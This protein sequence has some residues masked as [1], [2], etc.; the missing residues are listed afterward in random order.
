MWRPAK[1][2]PRLGALLAVAISGCILPTDGNIVSGIMGCWRD[3]PATTSSYNTVIATINRYVNGEGQA[4]GIVLRVVSEV[5]WPIHDVSQEAMYC[6]D[7]EVH[8]NLPPA[9]RRNYSSIVDG[10]RASV[11][12]A[13]EIADRSPRDRALERDLHNIRLNVSSYFDTFLQVNDIEKG[14]LYLREYSVLL[15]GTDAELIN[16]HRAAGNREE[17]EKW[18]GMLQRDC[19]AL[20]KYSYWF[21]RYQYSDHSN[22]G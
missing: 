7:E 9:V 22:E 4:P 10:F 5:I 12:A 15:L 6:F 13:L 8:G 19:Y 21:L 20:A 2:W 18:L 14:S 16:F 3:Q 1:F 17:A 11:N